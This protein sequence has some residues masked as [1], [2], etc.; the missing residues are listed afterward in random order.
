[1]AI[2]EN[3]PNPTNIHS[4]SHDMVRVAIQ[5]LKHNKA[6][7][8][9]GLPLSW[10]STQYTQLQG[11]KP[12]KHTMWANESYRKSTDRTW[13]TID[14]IF[15]LRQVLEK[16]SENHVDIHNIF[17]EY[18]TAIDIL[19]RDRVFAAISELGIQTNQSLTPQLAISPT[20][21]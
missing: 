4:P 12:F 2:G 3:A 18:K 7:G 16:T 10:D 9:D 19:I 15:T 5:Q 6:T 17:F 20:S 11:Y 21:S 14:Q 8:H 1:M 13:N